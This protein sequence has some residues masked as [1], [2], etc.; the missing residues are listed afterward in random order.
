MGTM[1]IVR[2]RTFCAASQNDVAGLAFARRG[3]STRVPLMTSRPSGRAASGRGRDL[4]PGPA[5]RV[6]LVEDDAVA[7]SELETFILECGH[8]VVAA[9]GTAPAAFRAAAATGPD[10]ALVDVRLGE[11]GDGIEFAEAIWRRSAIP[12]ILIAGL[13]DGETLHRARAAHPLD[14][15]VTPI[16][17]HR[18]RWSLTGAAALLRAGWRPAHRVAKR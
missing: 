3:Q 4:M 13:A 1:A 10:L 18:L 5:L 2:Y 12:S 6:L 11:S 14:L 9:A 16:L 15:L 17:P 7:A 8:E